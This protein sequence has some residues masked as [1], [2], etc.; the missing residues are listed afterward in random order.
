MISALRRSLDSWVA[1]GFFLIMVVAFIVWGVGDVVRLVG[2][3]TW[4]AKVAG[5]TIELPQAQQAF[6]QQ[7]TDVQRR[8]PSGTDVTPEMRRTI[9]MASVQGLIGQTVLAQ[10]QRR[11]GVVVPD[12][13][14]RQAVFAIPQFHGPSGQFDQATFQAVLRNNNMT[15]PQLLEIVRGRLAEQQ[16]L[17]T[18]T[19][20]VAPPDV[21]AKQVFAYQF[22]QRS[23]DLVELPFSA[24]PVPPPPAEAVLQ[25]WYDNHPDYYSTKEYRR[26]KAVVLSPETLAKDI[27]ITDAE[28]HAAYDAR[29]ALYVKPELRSVQVVQAPDQAK[30]AALAAQWRGAGGQPGADW[31]T[32][33]AAAK[34]A[35]GSAIELND[36]ERAGLPTAEL[37]RTVF[38]AVPDAISDPMSGLAGWQVLKVTKVTPGST[39]TFEQVQDQLRQLVLDSKAAD[40]IYDRANKV[41]NILASG[42]G[43]DELPSDLGLAGVAGT[44]D[45]EGNT[46]DG[47]PAPIPGG[48]AIRQALIEAAFKAHKGDPPQLTE[49]PLK[50]SRGSAYYA[51]RVEDVIPPAP[52]PFAQVRD[53]VLTDWR[54]DQQRHT[55]ETAAAH[56][57]TDVQHGQTLAQAAA[58]LGLT[59]TRTPLTGRDRAVSGMPPELLRPLFG[60]KPGEPTMV[61]EPEA[62]IVAVPAEILAPD[63]TSNP[64]GYEQVRT[65]LR[66]SLAQDV[67]EIFT[68]TLRDQ[69]HPSINQA[70]L[71]SISGQ[72]PDQ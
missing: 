2:T 14:V 43:L 51:L 56:L 36:T 50:G 47:K 1:R 57:L 21:L 42:S 60:L 13:A 6:Q 64:T 33:Q 4:V 63:T 59:V 32:M 48:D 38:A 8:M 61:E 49:V 30:A 65:A 26:I 58:G 16:L 15:E 29:K 35:G 34:A 45:A 17:G 39:Q 9:A 3:D 71:D 25:R 69:A 66:Q 72:Q 41:D 70:N 31:A 40:L 52:K 22:E 44:M 23:A 19:A 20:G 5:T 28:L 7:M 27:P 67:G 62:F 18:L 37:A 11:L 68:Q 54:Q 55:Q 10:E 12:A 53:T 46:L 24:A